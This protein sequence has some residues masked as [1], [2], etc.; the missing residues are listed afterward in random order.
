MK[1]IWLSD[2][3]LAP[4]GT[5]LFGIDPVKRLQHALNYITDHHL[6]ADYCVLSGDLVNNG[7]EA[8]YKLLAGLLDGLPMPVLTL[9][10]N[11]D[12]RSMMHRYFNYPQ[13]CARNFIQYSI[14]DKGIRLIALDTLHQGHAEGLLCEQRLAWLKSELETDSKVP[15]LVFCHHHPDALGLPMQD[16]E[17][18]LNGNHLLQMLI[19]AGNVKHLFF[20]HIHRPVSGSFSGLGFTALQSVSLQ[21]PLPYPMWDWDSFMPA[22]EAPAMGIIHADQ[23]NV[24]THFHAFCQPHDYVAQDN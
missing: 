12:D 11:H 16:K 17:R 1:L 10:G 21:A 23:S 7:D 18:L 13:N 19:D 3:H 6:D 8:S 20:G 9:P 15:T 5:L 4:E 2:L 22:T 14:T 24:I